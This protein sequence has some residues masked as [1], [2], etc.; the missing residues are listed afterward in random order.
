[1]NLTRVS[2]ILAPCCHCR[3]TRPCMPNNVCG[4]ASTDIADS[5]LVCV[6]GE[7]AHASC[8]RRQFEKPDIGEWGQRGPDESGRTKGGGCRLV[9]AAWWQ[10][11]SKSNQNSLAWC[12]NDNIQ[13]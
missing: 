12:A 7:C 13:D 1:M 3:W 10:V 11:G 9:D 2:Q 4:G 5:V 6:R 8:A